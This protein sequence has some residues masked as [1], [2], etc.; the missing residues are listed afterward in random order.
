MSTTALTDNTKADERL[1]SS[2][3]TNY[4]AEIKETPKENSP[5]T[6]NNE[7][8][9][10]EKAADYP[11]PAQAALVMVSVLLALFLTALDRTIIATAIPAM[12]DE[13]HS[14]DDIGWYGSAF[15][16]TSCC[17]TLFLGRVYTFYSPKYVYLSLILIFEIG[18]AV[19]GA[20]P[21]SIA[22]IIGRAIQGAGSA[23]MMS[24]GMVLLVNTLPLAKRPLW[25]GAVGATFGIAS[26]VGP[27]LG[28]AFTSNV[29]WR[30]CFYINLP[31]GAVTMLAI[32]LLLKNM[33]PFKKGLNTKDKLLQLDP[34]G[35][36]FLLPCLVCL[37][38]ALQWGGSSLAWSNGKIIALLVLFGV[39]MIAFIVV[40]VTTQKTATIPAAIVKNR[41]ML[42]GCFFV[43][44]VAASMMLMVYFIPIWFQ[45][46]KGV[47]AVESGIRTIPMVLSLV[48]GTIVSGALTSK[49]GYYTQF[50]YF[51]AIV[52][53]VAAGLISMWKVNTGHG[54]WIGYQVLYGFAL[55]LG[56][57]QANLAAQTV[58]KRAD[59][60]T[61]LALT[62]FAQTMGGAI[63]ISVGQNVLTSNLVK[64]ITQIVTDIDPQ[65][66][67]NTGA[68]DLRELVPAELLPD[69]LEVYNNALRQVFLIS[70]GMAAVSVIGA[71]GL[72][73]K[74]VKKTEKKAG[75]GKADLKDHEKD[76]E[77][78]GENAV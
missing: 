5:A 21:N 10:D 78:A 55:G 54:E 40:Q 61:G 39:L 31:I 13:F 32:M 17:F 72:E 18:S 24:G 63:F 56:M 38:L 66:I 70:A 67:V 46:V 14:L 20:A 12:T 30:W 74:N 36:F 27:L 57:Q 8:D 22:F 1:G 16:L 62:V 43:F 25:M 15:L 52:M 47:S 48:L 42:A 60:P 19:C 73:W 29:S 35:T 77:K 33:E 76:S 9:D 64:G 69:V 45:A 75:S 3:S 65:S 2:S 6:E 53:P 37:L 50:A 49:I 7:D 28:G 34:L 58:L 68:T 23:G 71:L 11:P 41:S 44:N 59:V 26:V 4:D 51:S